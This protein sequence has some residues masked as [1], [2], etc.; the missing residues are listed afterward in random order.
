LL[1]LQIFLILP[2]TAAAFYFDILLTAAVGPAKT[3]LF[4]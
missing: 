3:F 1:F 4:S 2:N